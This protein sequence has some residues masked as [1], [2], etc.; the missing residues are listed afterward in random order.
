MSEGREVDWFSNRH[1]TLAYN[2]PTHL[3]ARENTLV[4]E[5]RKRDTRAEKNYFDLEDKLDN[6]VEFRLRYLEKVVEIMKQYD[7]EIV[8][9]H[10][11]D[12]HP[13][14]FKQKTTAEKLKAQATIAPRMDA[15]E[16][17]EMGFDEDEIKEDRE[18]EKELAKND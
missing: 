1:E 7:A 4:K 12:N 3:P 13:L 15:D 14:F 11:S 8:E 6:S 2:L 18:T 9:M 17:R 10:F 5:M 16:A